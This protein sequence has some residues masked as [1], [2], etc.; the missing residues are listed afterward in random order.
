MGDATQRTGLK[1]NSVLTRVAPGAELTDSRG[2]ESR[3]PNPESFA[4][5]AQR[6]DALVQVGSLDAEDAR[7]PG[8]IPVRLLEGLDDALAFCRVADPVKID[9]WRGRWES[10]LHGDRIDRDAVPR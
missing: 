2:A 7:R 4:V 8:H 3:I 10:D 5:E 1:G 6:A 9:R